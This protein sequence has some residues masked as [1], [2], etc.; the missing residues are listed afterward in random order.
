MFKEV[1]RKKLPMD[2]KG[3]CASLERIIAEVDPE[4]SLSDN[5][6]Y[7]LAFARERYA[8][9]L[10]LLP[11]ERKVAVLE[12]GWHPGFF[13]LLMKKYLHPD[14]VLAGVDYA[15]NQGIEERQGKENVKPVKTPTG[16]NVYNCNIEH[17]RFPLKDASFDVVLCTEVI[18]H[19]L[20]H[21][22]HM[23]SEIF[24]VL[25]PGGQAIFSTPNVATTEMKLTFLF[26]LM[27]VYPPLKAYR[28]PP[29]ERHNREY[30]QK[31]LLELLREHGFRI[32]RSWCSP[33]H[34]K[35]QLR[36]D[37]GNGLREVL[38]YPRVW[39]KMALPFLFPGNTQFAVAVKPLA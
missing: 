4:K 30:T 36:L 5:E 35:G 33:C 26:G 31:E 14:S 38:K 21:P 20:M 11:Q 29:Y 17:E 24:R 8:E 16:M 19:L 15:P 1:R 2:A 39:L 13:T 28:K 37:S 12:V 23:V 3:L 7:Y 9:T 10:E 18:E 25:K 6:K 27:N 34:E 32:E 22:G